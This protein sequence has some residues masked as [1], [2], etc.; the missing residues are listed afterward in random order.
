MQKTSTLVLSTIIEN[1]KN[2]QQPESTVDDYSPCENTIQ[3][4]LNFSKSL[5]VKKSRY[6]GYIENLKS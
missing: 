1:L 6:L 2:K 4:I 5:E 3:N